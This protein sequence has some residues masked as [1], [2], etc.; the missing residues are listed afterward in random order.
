[1]PLRILLDEHIKPDIA[2]R[3]TEE[4]VDVVCARD[5][6][7]ANRKI[8]DWELMR[9]CIDHGRSVCTKNAKDLEREHERCRARGED[10]PGVLT[11]GDWSP[12]AIYWALR[13]YLESQ[14]DPA[15][16]KNQVV[17]VLE[18]SEEFIHDRSV[19]SN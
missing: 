12:D 9:W 8:P 16:A 17:P 1:V 2:H 19:G 5:R 3:L 6:G 15:L 10:H 7:L 11:V 14:P 4:G 13:Q 18:A